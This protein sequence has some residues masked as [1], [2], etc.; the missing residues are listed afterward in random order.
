MTDL[1]IEQQRPPYWWAVA[2]GAAVLA[3][4]MATLAPTTA[5]WDTSEYIA[6]AYTLGIPHPPGNPLFTL[7]AHT[8]GALPLAASYAE[9]I[10]LFAAVTSAASAAFWFLV[11]ERW[12]RAMVPARGVRIATAVA[13]AIVG[14]TAW[15]VWN[16]S[17]VNEKVYTV[18]LLT[19]A[20]TAWLT[21][22]WADLAP[23][24]KRDRLLILVVYVT[25]LSSTNHM[26]GV[27]VAP[28]VVL[29]VLMNDWRVFLRPGML[30]A[31]V[32]VVIVGFS[33]N[34]FLLVRAPHF[35]GINEG[36]PTSLHALSDV[37]NRKQ[38][39]KPSI[40]DRQASILSQYQN[41]LQ[42][43]SWQFAGDCTRGFT[44]GCSW[45]GRLA[46]V[47]F[48]MLGVGGL[49]G[50]WA[51]DR[52]SFWGAAALLGTFT[53][54]LVF[55]LNFK[56]GYSIHPERTDLIREVRERDYFFIVSFGMWGVFVAAGFAS[57]MGWIVTFLRDRGNP[58]QRWLMASPVLALALIP[59]LFNRSTASRAGEH[60]A[61]DLAVDLLQSV[62]PYGILV[63]AGDNDTF[64]LW[65]AQEVEGV[66]RDVTLVNLSLANT[67][68]HLR[69]L[70]RRKV[71]RF[72]PSRSIELWK[73]TPAEPVDVLTDTAAVDSTP[74]TP[75][76]PDFPVFD[77]TEAALDSIPDLSLTPQGGTI[78]FGDLTLRFGYQQLEKADVAVA[79]LIKQNLG[80]R[81]IYF[82]LSAGDYPD[83]TLGLS[84]YLVTEGLVRRL[85]PTPVA[86][87]DSIV[88]S[89][90]FGYVNLP[91]TEELM[92]NAYHWKTAAANRP[93]GW[94]D[95]PSSPILSLYSVVY[96]LMGSTLLEQGDTTQAIRA[97]SVARAVM[98]NVRRSRR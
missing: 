60:M 87:N 2:V 45:F 5:F 39:G 43:F 78:R 55:Y 33:L 58:R 23:G 75:E 50:L 74:G 25:A 62:E 6:A 80:R 92:W 40:F 1:T 96:G 11:A 7:L 88:L 15:T 59:V 69:Q 63:T 83:R 20:L 85:N 84:P 27:L 9:R 10:N 56:Y 14:A 31:M 65:Y 68:W 57:L 64:P 17:T 51:A 54:A 81:P 35:P 47:L 18:S 19:I 41:Y 73:P 34:G 67:D 26:M 16:Q 36:E 79:L 98:Q 48:G 86:P 52:K 29:Y 70:R 89:A 49:L 97:D 32:A 46:A 4:Y 3:I 82:S 30:A 44:P 13:G 22:H 28:M 21:V 12:L 93:E 37:L 72:D 76:R 24:P 42:Y 95:P 94:Y 77:V 66:R 38:Y 61:R 90:G 71:E 53:V 91:R 8:W